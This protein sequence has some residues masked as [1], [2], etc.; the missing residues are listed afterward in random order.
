M[1]LS[2]S[3]FND[4]DLEFV[5]QQVWQSRCAITHRRFGGTIML[6]LTRWDPSQPPSPYNCV[7]MMQQ[8]AKHLLE[9]GPSFF[10]EETQL[11]IAKRL[12]WAKRVFLQEIEPFH[13]GPQE[14]YW[15][16]AFQKLS[17]A[18]QQSVLRPQQGQTEPLLAEQANTGLL[19]NVSSCVSYACVAA[20]SV[21]AT[22]LCHWYR[23]SQ[24]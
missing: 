13:Y 9:Q 7:L 19:Q 23:L 17:P 12:E 4:E 6:T 5:V 22:S 18:Q 10:P 8:E 16:E 3:V 15:P 21:V 14:L 11:K 24:A 1:E 20:V 2:E